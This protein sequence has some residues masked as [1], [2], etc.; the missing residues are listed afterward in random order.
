V[1]VLR[2]RVYD[3]AVRI[4]GRGLL[5]FLAGWALFYIVAAALGA[6]R[7]VVLGSWWHRKVAK[8]RDV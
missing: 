4:V 3:S 8:P 2:L 6:P 7:F 5:V 1:A